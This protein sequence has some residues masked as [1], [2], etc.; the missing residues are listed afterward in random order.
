MVQIGEELEGRFLVQE[1]LGRG[2]FGVVA[3]CVDLQTNEPVAVKIIKNRYQFY[4]QAKIEIGILKDL[5]DKDQEN[6]YN[7]VQMKHYFIWRKHLCLVFELLS[8]NLY[9]L[10]KYTKFKGVSLNLIRKFSQQLLLALM[11]LSRSDVRIIHCDLKPENILLK[12]HRKSAIKVIDFG[13]S[14]YVNKK[15][16]KYIQ[17]R[18]YR[19]PE[20]ILGNPYNCSIDMWSLGCIMI[21]MHIGVPLFDGK[22]EHDQIRKIAS[23]LGM[24]PAHLIQKSPK[25]HKFFFFDTATQTY[26]IKLPPAA[27]QIPV[28][29]LQEIIGVYSGGPGG[30]RLNQPG[31][32][33]QDYLYFYD[34]VSRMLEYD[35]DKRIRPED[36]LNH[37][38]FTRYTSNTS[39]APSPAVSADHLISPRL[40]VPLTSTQT[41]LPQYGPPASPNNVPSSAMYNVAPVSMPM[42]MSSTIPVHVNQQQQQHHMQQMYISSQLQQQQ[43]PVVQQAQQSHMLQHSVPSSNNWGTSLQQQQQPLSS[44]HQPSTYPHFAREQTASNSMYG[45]AVQPPQFVQSVQQPMKLSSQQL[46]QFTVNNL[47]P[48]QSF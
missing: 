4:Q 8:Y 44:V 23:I 7:I 17:S 6:R 24:P 26:K 9:D 20:V 34:L 37:E 48:R 3:K 16:Y 39:A 45:V 10:L 28:R 29:S 12:N 21:E 5:N 15:M 46:P 19:S 33:A 1:V 27:T 32:S 14:C 35:P 22:D 31:H 38:F 42:Q 18:F 47:Y 30:R 25:K 43:I 40:D 41:G 36:A 11:F 13:S 2:S